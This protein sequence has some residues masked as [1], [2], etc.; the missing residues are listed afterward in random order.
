MQESS[1]SPLRFSLCREQHAYKTSNFPGRGKRRRGGGSDIPPRTSQGGG[2]GLRAD[3]S[4]SA[5]G[6]G[7]VLAWPLALVAESQAAQKS[8]SSPSSTRCNQINIFKVAAESAMA[9]LTMSTRTAAAAG[10][11]RRQPSPRRT[12]I[13]AVPLQNQRRRWTPQLTVR[14]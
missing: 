14:R 3:R 7:G 6:L 13:L 2:G 12:S 11:R 10:A 9:D 8:F 5:L 1:S 4:L